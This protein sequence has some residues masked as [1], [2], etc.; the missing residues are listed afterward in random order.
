MTN[1]SEKKGGGLIYNPPMM[2]F[3]GSTG[4]YSATY[5]SVGNKVTLVARF[6]RASWTGNEVEYIARADGPTNTIRAGLFIHSSDYSTAVRQSKLGVISRNSAN[7][8]IC[9]MF[10]SSVLAD[11]EDHE[12][13][14]EF[15]GDA[16]TAVFRVDGVDADDTGNAERIAPTTGALASGAGSGFFVGSATSGVSLLFSGMI[17]RVGVID[18]GDLVWSDYMDQYGNPKP[19]DFSA[20]L[21]GHF[22]G[23]MDENEGTAGAMTKNGTI[24]LADPGVCPHIGLPTI[25]TAVAA[26]IATGKIAWVNGVEIVGTA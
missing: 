14:Y 4:F 7:T 8:Q 26:D 9:R 16:G 25:G 1:L 2:Q 24:T 10:S 17:G 11:G 19:T 20:W 5:T 23:K 6:N 13:F 3:D 15:D 22:A 12:V 18:S 21:F